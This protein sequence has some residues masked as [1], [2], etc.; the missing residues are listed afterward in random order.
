M[1]VSCKNYKNDYVFVI[2]STRKEQA[3]LLYFILLSCKL[4]GAQELEEKLTKDETEVAKYL[5]WNLKT[6]KSAMFGEEVFYF[7]G[8]TF[9]AILKSFL[10]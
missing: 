5:R 3:G 1:L 8:L 4:Q 9:Y 6:K 10:S 2:P 7:T